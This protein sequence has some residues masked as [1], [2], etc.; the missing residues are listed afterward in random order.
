MRSGWVC[1]I[2][3]LA[4]CGGPGEAVVV[5]GVAISEC[6]EFDPEEPPREE[7][8]L[9]GQDRAIV[10][11]HRAVELNCCHEVEVQARTDEE[12]TGIDVVYEDKA[13][14]PCDCTCVYD[15]GFTLSDLALG[16]WQVRVPSQQAEIELN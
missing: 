4:S 15:M 12:G 14:E 6:L 16:T 1:A 8:L 11:A 7:L 10:V 2:L 3:T 5:D 9:T 13:K